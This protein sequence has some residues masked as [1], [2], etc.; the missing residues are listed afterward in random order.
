MGLNTTLGR[1]KW[2]KWGVRAYG[3]ANRGCVLIGF[4]EPCTA[5]GGVGDVISFIVKVLRVILG[6]GGC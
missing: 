1:Y 4:A 5:I 3:N 2:G 6:D